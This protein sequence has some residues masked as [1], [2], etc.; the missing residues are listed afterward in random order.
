VPERH[1]VTHKK[2]KVDIG[3]LICCNTPHY[4]QMEHNDGRNA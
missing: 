4:E 1:T 3:A 2:L